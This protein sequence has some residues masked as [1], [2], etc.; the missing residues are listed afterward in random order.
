MRIVSAIDGPLKDEHVIDV[1]PPLRPELPGVWRRRLNPF[2]GRALSD[3][4]LAAEQEVRAGVQRLRGQSVTAGIVNGL[5]LLLEP[6]A[7]GAK[8]D[9]ALFQL[10]PGSGLTQGGEDVVL[11]SPR[12]LAFG[13]LPVYARV[14]H[15][16]AIAADEPA[17]PPAPASGAASPS[18][19][20][21]GG[22]YANLRPALPRR[23]GPQLKTL[24]GAAAAAGLPR[25]AILVA[26]PIT[27]T[28]LGRPDADACPRDPRD[29]P[30]DDL[31]LIDGCRLSLYL[32]PS[33]ITAVSGGAD[34]SLPSPGPG[35]RN[36]LAYR[37]F[38]VE[39]G[40]LPTEI[41]PWE[42][43]GTPLA[44][45]AFNDDWSLNFVD[46]AAVARLGGQPNP[47][48]PLAPFS[49]AAVLW[50][51]R[52]A[53]FVE[54]LAELDDLKPAT[55]TA[56]FRQLPPVGFLPRAV[57]DLAT[58]RQTFFPPGFTLNAVPV[59][60]EHIDLVV[61]E[62]ASLA[63]LNL[64]T[65]DTVELLVPVPER[66]YEPGLLEIATVD[67]DFAKAMARYTADRTRWLVRREMVRRRRDLLM[68]GATGQRAAWRA[69]DLPAAETLPYPATR[70]PVTCTR[71][72]RITAGA[73][74]KAHKMSGAGSSLE[75]A[76]DDR[77]YVWV[78]VVD[79]ANLTS[80]SLKAGA[81]STAD[82]GGDFSYAVYWGAPDSLPPMPGADPAILKRGAL[83]P[84][85]AW[86]RLDI[87]AS[88]AW[89][90]TGKT[91]VGAKLNG[92]DF[93]QKGGTV[94][95]GPVGKLTASGAEVVYLGDDAPPAATLR[96]DSAAPAI[97][98][99]PFVPAGFD[100]APLEDAYGTVEAGGVRSI[101]ALGAFQARWPQPFLTAD[102]DLLNE[103]GIDGFIAALDARLKATNDA[104]DL[105]FVRARADIYRVRSYML[106]ADA[107]SR[108][109]TSPAL[110]DLAVREEGA[111]A[112]S[113]DLSTFVKAAYQTDFRRD[114]NAPLETK[115][116]TAPGG[117]PGVAAIAAVA[118]PAFTP[119]VF[120]SGLTL[121]LMAQPMLFAQPVAA[122]AQPKT[123]TFAASSAAVSNL[124][125]SGIL[126]TTPKAT[127]NYRDIQAQL[128]LPGRIER[129]VSVAERLKPAPAVEAHTYALEGKYT[130]LSTIAGLIDTAAGATRPKGIAL[131][132][133]PAPGFSYR[134]AGAPPPGRVKNTVGDVIQDRN[135][136][137]SLREYDDLDDLKE[138]VAKHEADYFNASVRA[139]DNTVAMMRLVEG[140]VE[141]Y[142]RLIADAHDVREQLD[143]LIAQTDARLR[144]IGVELEEARHDVGVASALL[145]EEQIRVDELNARRARILEDHAR[146]VMFRRPRGAGRIHV[147]PTSP[148]S[149]ALV[150]SPVTVCLREHEAVPEEVREF[151]ALLREA[152]VN[153]F[154]AIAAQLQLLDRLD[155]ARAA[156]LAMR[157]RAATPPWIL[158]MVKADGAPKLL[159]AVHTAFTAQQALLD[160]RRAFALQLDFAVVA[161]LD[162]AVAQREIGARAS[163]ADLIAG[164]HN[165]PA[166]AR[167]AASEVEAVGQVA[168]C[169]HESFGEAPP[170]IRLAWAEL[171][172]AFD[173]PAPL[174]RLAGLPRWN[175]LPLELKRTQ[176]GFVDWL[177]SRID[178][179]NPNA[180]AAVNELVRV[181]LLMAAHA[182][183]DRILPAH[184]VGA[185]KA[186]VGTRLDLA[187]D[188]RHAR[189]GMVAM[190]RADD[191]KAVAHAVIDDIADGVARAR[192]T[193]TYLPAATI[194]AGLRI[195]LTAARRG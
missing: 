72:R 174:S 84:T 114:P 126:A 182:P 56:A 59:P 32:W 70:G 37:V 98:P 61:R 128:A 101:S 149:A 10:L 85:G 151:A 134:P 34:Y 6:G 88:A 135:K 92:L 194:P 161:S 69:D 178:R 86:T 108:L 185:V 111:R 55:L 153:W 42:K 191:G 136:V 103:V 53:Q 23:M 97:L 57:I 146:M 172:S 195:D 159:Q 190:I 115:A 132:D 145:A 50:Q 144:N 36:R 148:A 150:E 47:R 3:K 167:Q 46:R 118:A 120:N 5:D 11:G 184:L 187:V 78:R 106:G 188:I 140:R 13:D 44:L 15:L 192:I 79:A 41:H 8:P 155:A 166:L 64:D 43:L 127:I 75:I 87:P 156:L 171:L 130:V 102:F 169:L 54:Q 186:Q 19:T 143:A 33:E 170:I 65:P 25:V 52:V 48:T 158:Q 129:T 157:Q 39:R 62:S 137:E 123:A 63:P 163:L 91:L 81:G 35:Q 4:A 109:V 1:D 131:G 9:K 29:D 77:L 22:A 16:D 80:L 83:P 7:R 168:A 124:S 93:G 26:E 110:A 119:M 138:S 152:P 112:K 68:D 100:A 176:Q 177:F 189:I 117:A 30:Y 142:N 18:E 66:V 116:P 121:G 67:P 27:A 154:P 89:G 183:V 24:I 122:A 179:G 162:L 141:L 2:T 107:A 73:A 94:E 165:R 99:W 139:I 113:L 71:V 51:A 49:G 147:L 173:N 160:Q 90:M 38:A 164:D 21:P 60:L 193:Q 45:V 74:V 20:L 105:G 181:C 14:D 40:A 104:I 95:W 175:E 82:G 58:R 12:R 28:I 76:A 180:E 96:G 31:Q 125:L 17:T 133:L